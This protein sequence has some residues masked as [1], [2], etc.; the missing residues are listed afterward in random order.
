MDPYF[1]CWLW[2]TRHNEL[3]WGERSHGIIG[4]IESYQELL[5]LKNLQHT[6]R[7]MTEFI[8]NKIHHNQS[9]PC[10]SGLPFK[11]CHRN[12]IQE[13]E[14]NLPKGQLIHDFLFILGGL[15]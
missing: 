6:I 4:L 13:L 9:C 11:K 12:T 10:E 7:F 5:K 14:Y 3:P 1:L 15:K 8:K 2:Y